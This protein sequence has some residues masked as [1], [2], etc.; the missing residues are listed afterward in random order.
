MATHAD[1]W[2]LF[3]G[4]GRRD[5][6]GPFLHQGPPPIEEVGPLVG[7]LHPVRIDMRERRLAAVA[8][9]VGALCRSCTMSRDTTPRHSGRS[10]AAERTS[11]RGSREP[12]RQCCARSTQEAIDAYAGAF[13]AGFRNPDGPANVHGL[14]DEGHNPDNLGTTP[15]HSATRLP[16]RGRRS[17]SIPTTAGHG[18]ACGWA[19]RIPGIVS[20][21]VRPGQSVSDSC[22]SRIG[23]SRHGSRWP[24]PRLRCGGTP[25]RR[26]GHRRVRG[27]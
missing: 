22:N 19:Q 14:V 27:A 23:R 4:P 2:R 10:G 3:A 21:T 13:H 18:A 6:R 24:R 20:C 11:S 8:R 16:T 12:A 5:V 25:C 26:I 1:F 15:W 7:G 9:R 17:S